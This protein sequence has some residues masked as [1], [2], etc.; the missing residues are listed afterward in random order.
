MKTS[1]QTLSMGLILILILAACSSG[2]QAENAPDSAE[3][4][5]AQELD[6]EALEPNLSDVA[7]SQ[8]VSGTDPQNGAQITANYPANWRASAN[9]ARI[10]LNQSDTDLSI[11]IR[12]LGAQAMAN[13]AEPVG[14][15]MDLLASV[16]RTDDTI[17]FGQLTPLVFDNREAAYGISEGDERFILMLAIK[18]SD[19]DYV[20]VTAQSDDLFTTQEEALVQSIANSVQYTAGR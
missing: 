2:G 8:Q 6:I 17:R 19:T 7:L 18:F 9:R 11:N 20:L 1:I 15:P 16:D 4:S 3:D 13:F 10:E 14:A 12:A 5:A